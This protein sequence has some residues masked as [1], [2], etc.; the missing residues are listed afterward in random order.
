MMRFVLFFFAWT[1]ATG[2]AAADDGKKVTIRWHGQSF[3]EIKSSAG[4]RIVIDPHAIEQFGRIEVE[5]D[6]ILVTHLHSDHMRLEVI[7]NAAD[8]KSV[9]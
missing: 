3:F 9:V 1:A 2:F 4:T 5:A 6:L 8:R 7:T